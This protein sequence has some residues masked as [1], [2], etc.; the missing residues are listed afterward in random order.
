MSTQNN[1]SSNNAR[2]NNNKLFNENSFKSPVAE[3]IIG[4]GMITSFAVPTYYKF[5]PMLV[6]SG[7]MMGTMLSVYFAAQPLV[8][9]IVAG[10]FGG[11]FSVAYYT[12][13]LFQ[14]LD[15]SKSK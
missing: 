10:T 7:T 3:I 12:Q 14:K 2:T 11:I 6:A 15:S 5:D 4:T 9:T 1:T 8:V 13:K